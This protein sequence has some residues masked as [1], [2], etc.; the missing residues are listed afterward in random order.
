MSKI[1]TTSLLTERLRKAVTLGPT[2]ALVMVADFLIEVTGA[3]LTAQAAR[4][5]LPELLD[6]VRKGEIQTI[7]TAPEEM[8]LLV[9]V[10][11]L[12]GIIRSVSQPE[13]LGDPLDA[14]G[15]LPSDEH[16]LTVRSGR[17]RRKP[18]IQNDG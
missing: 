13:T 1:T 16:R 14:I 11:D 3:K 12:T 9:S 15:F 18:R 2:D 4:D 6:R 17:P 7:G 5:N 8:V 10:R